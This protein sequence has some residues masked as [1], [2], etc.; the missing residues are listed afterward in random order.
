MVFVPYVSERPELLAEYNALKNDCKIGLFGSY[1]NKNLTILSL[2]QYFLKHQGYENTLLASDLYERYPRRKGEHRSSYDV[3]ISN[4]LIRISNVHIFVIFYESDGQH[5]I[6]CSAFGE[7]QEAKK[8]RKKNI[9]L[10]FDRREKKRISTY[11]KPYFDDPPEGWEIEAYKDDIKT[12]HDHVLGFLWNMCNRIC[13][14][15]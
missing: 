11:Y 13:S 10:Y 9:I 8:Q 4:T 6:N 2:L 3:R 15:H 1:E 12:K 14:N 5:G 7:M